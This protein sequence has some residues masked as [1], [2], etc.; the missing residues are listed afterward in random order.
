MDGPDLPGSRR[1]AEHERRGTVSGSDSRPDRDRLREEHSSRW[2]L[3]RQDDNGLKFLVCIRK[4]RQEAEEA[5]K[6]FERLHH[7]Q[8][9]FV[10][11]FTG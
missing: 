1:Q 11:P 4:T 3:W 9:Y 5:Q 2:A 7:K 6:A 8:L 10:E